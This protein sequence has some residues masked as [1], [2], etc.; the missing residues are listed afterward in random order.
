MKS[1]M[2][3]EQLRDLAEKILLKNMVE[4]DN[5]K[6]YSDTD[7]IVNA[8]IEFYNTKPKNGNGKESEDHKNSI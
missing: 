6:V 1:L 8:M 4:N 7:V 3:P 5:P 2:T